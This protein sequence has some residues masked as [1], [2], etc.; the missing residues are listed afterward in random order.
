MLQ[1]RDGWGAGAVAVTLE[2]SIGIFARASRSRFGARARHKTQER[3]ELLAKKGDLEGAKVHEQV[4]Q[5]I[6][7]LEQQSAPEA[8]NRG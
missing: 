7:R 3:V 5:Q 2:Q 4:V 6:L 8:A 1:N